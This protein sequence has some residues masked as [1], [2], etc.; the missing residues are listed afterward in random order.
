VRTL[1][2]GPGENCVLVAND[3]HSA[4]VPLL[5]KEEYQPKGEFKAAKTAFCIHNIA[6]QVRT[7]RPLARACPR[8]RPPREERPR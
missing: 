2:F 1:P 5:I 8:P 3:W 6:F 7:S 4:L